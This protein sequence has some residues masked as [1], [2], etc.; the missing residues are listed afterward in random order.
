MKRFVT[1]V[2]ICFLALPFLFQPASGCGE[3]PVTAVPAGT[4][5]PA[6]NPFVFRNGVIWGMNPQQIALIENVPMELRST[7]EWSVM[8]TVSPVSVSRFS[9]S[10]VYMFHQNALRM[11][12]YEFQSNCSNLN[13]QYLTGAL[14]SVYGES[15]EASPVAVKGWMDRINA[16]KYRLELI[17]QVHEWTA[18]DGTHIYLFYYT[19]EN[20][21]ILYVCPESAGG[22]T[23]YDTNGL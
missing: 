15:R 18:E 8:V 21:A 14:C 4:E 9:A 7:T 10:L 23:G 22:G 1:G 3:N 16:D 6:P 5:T 17:Q 13:F 19:S 11:I 2:F 12:T 20:Y